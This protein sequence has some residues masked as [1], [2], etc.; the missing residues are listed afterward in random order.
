MKSFI[1]FLT[2]FILLVT[3][4]VINNTENN[5]KNISVLDGSRMT[6][7]GSIILKNS[8]KV[9]LNKK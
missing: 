5:N 2:I 4:V 8:E 6:P 3:L 9:D 7:D 1:V